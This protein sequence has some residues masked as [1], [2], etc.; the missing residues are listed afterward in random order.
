MI[1]TVARV[2]DLDRFVRAFSTIGRDKRRQHGC[3]GAQVFRDPDDAQRVWV[4]FDWSDA[5]Y[6]GFL[7]DPEIPAVARE[8]ALAEPPV[9]IRP[10]VELDS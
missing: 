9:T 7:A 1:V 6:D 2:A 5:D 8:L 4:C 3:R 10:I